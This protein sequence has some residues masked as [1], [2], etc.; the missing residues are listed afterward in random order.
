MR[1]IPRGAV[2]C[3]AWAQPGN[4]TTLKVPPVKTSIDGEGGLW[5]TIA[6]EVRLSAEQLRGVA[7]ELAH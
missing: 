7:K 4:P 6:G 3:V 1:K 2:A 5:P